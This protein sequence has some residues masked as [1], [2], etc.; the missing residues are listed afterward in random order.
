VRSIFHGLNR[1]DRTAA[2]ATLKLGALA[3]AVTVPL[4][5]TQVIVVHTALPSLGTA[6]RET[7]GYLLGFELYFYALHRL[8]HVRGL[9]RRIHIVHH[10]SVYPSALTGLVLH[11]VEAVLIMAFVPVAMWTVPIHLVSL[12]CVSAFL[13]ASILLAHADVDWVPVWWER[14]PV[15]NWYVTPRVHGEHHAH[16]VTNYGSTL[17]ICDRVFGTFAAP[18][19]SR[20]R[21]TRDGVDHRGHRGLARRTGDAVDRLTIPPEQDQHRGSALGL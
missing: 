9:Y 15:L 3:V 16:G 6:A 1:H 5:Y 17:S 12:A 7:F 14:V 20:S 18:A 10:R 11:P 13:S 21:G 2:I 8:L 19:A 4:V